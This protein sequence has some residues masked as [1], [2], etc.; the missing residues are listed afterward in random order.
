MSTGIVFWSVVVGALGFAAAVGLA[1]AL[2]PRH[3]A[4][5]VVRAV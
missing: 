1:V 2:L 3:D 4:E 5:D